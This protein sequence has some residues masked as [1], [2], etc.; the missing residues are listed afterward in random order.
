MTTL[1]SFN[2]YRVIRH[3]A[4]ATIALLSLIAMRGG[5]DAAELAEQAHSLRVVPA[6]VAYYSSSLRLKEQLDAF[7]NSNAY[8]RLMEIQLVQFAKGLIQTQWQQASLPA[9]Q[10][11][12]DYVESDEGQ[13]VIEVLKEMFADEIFVYGGNDLTDWLQLFAELN[14]IQQRV[15]LE[16]S[17]SDED[18]QQLLKKRMLRIFE[19]R[20]DGLDAPTIVAGFRIN[21]AD[22]ARQQLDTVQGH[23]RQLLDDK[24]PELSANLQRDQ[25]A[26]NEFLT[27]RLDG[28][29]IPWDQVREEIDDADAE[30][31][32]KWR[33][34]ISKKTIAL[35]LGVIENVVLISVGESTDHLENFGKGPFLADHEALKRLAKH[36][37]ERVIS[38]SYLSAE[39]AKNL[40]S[41]Q[42]T[43]NDLANS[44]DQALV[45]AEIEEPLRKKLIE[46]I[47]S[48]DLAKYMPVPGET[49]SIAFITDRGYEAFRYQTGTQPLLDSSK[50][51]EILDHIGGSPLMCVASRSNDTVEDYDRATAW[52]KKTAG[53]V[54][55]IAKSKSKP[56]DWDTYLEYRD[57]VIALL[58]RLD[59]ANR[60]LVYP[61]LSKSE[62]AIVLDASAES[63]QWTTHAPESPTALPM[64]EFGIVMSVSD[65]EHLRKAVNEYVEVFRDG[66]ALAREIN[67]DSLPDFEIPEAEE[68]N[69][70]GGGKLYVYPLP[71]PWG[72]DEQLAPT[73]G[74]TESTA[75]L[76]TM[77]ATAERL[78][79]ATPQKI[80]TSLDLT[81]P[82]AAV[83]HIKFAD[84]LTK[85]RPW[86]D[87][88]LAVGMGTLKNE[89]PED[90]GDENDESGSAD[91]EEAEVPAQAAQV[92]FQVGI[93]MPQVYQ[94][95]DVLSAFR[96]VT[97]I[98][99]EED[100][101]W[102][103]HSE[104][105]I[106][107]LEED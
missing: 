44:L 83:V 10:E 1:R 99:Y 35:A 105:N 27:L 7:L 92:A 73:A 26:G 77:P 70:E 103:T 14:G 13:E 4:L 81:R 68:R 71:D 51:L 102:V 89:E 19:E 37:D 9:V 75:V 52:L 54:E 47:Q 53:H 8:A 57:R 16:A 36:S 40:S 20:A 64:L 23:L 28:S 61:A 29:M 38:I 39:F 76:S 59:A 72:I 86:I 67:P 43:L 6:D 31:F 41:P 15:R 18:F 84:L 98:T 106:Q 95:F 107:D 66:I 65:A 88:G 97:M 49:S 3:F 55:E 79:Q 34:L 30:D 78:L 63:K 100:G 21:D 17:T 25:I 42:K 101:V 5:A 60:N 24:Q 12:R 62:A 45:E 91:D 22:K 74:L 69:A 96:S 93:F 56:E 58:N 82:A 80:D 94:L 32:E 90:D 85:I 46:D 87:Y 11:F 48:L 33:E 2:P 50:P 104:T